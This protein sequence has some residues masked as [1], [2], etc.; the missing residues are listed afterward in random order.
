MKKLKWSQKFKKF[1]PIDN[2]LNHWLK[3]QSLSMH[4]V[5]YMRYQVFKLNIEQNDCYVWSA[6]LTGSET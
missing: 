5:V 2:S 3:I 1:K 6:A 4:G